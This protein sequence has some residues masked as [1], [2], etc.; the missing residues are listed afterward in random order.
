M[1]PPATNWNAFHTESFLCDF[2]APQEALFVTVLWCVPNTLPIIF[3]GYENMPGLC[4]LIAT[5]M[6]SKEMGVAFPP[7]SNIF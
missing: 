3:I 7:H 6:V 2:Y 1:H 5:H 4:S